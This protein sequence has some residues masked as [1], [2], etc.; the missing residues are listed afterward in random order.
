MPV[1][2]FSA[3]QLKANLAERTVTLEGEARLRINQ[4]AIRGRQP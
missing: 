1:G 2:T 4:N 3:N